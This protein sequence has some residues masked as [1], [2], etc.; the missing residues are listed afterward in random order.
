MRDNAL[1]ALGAIVLLTAYA[2]ASLYPF[3]PLRWGFPRPVSNGAELLQEGGI[4]FAAPGIARSSGPPDWVAAALRSHRLELSLRLR[5]FAPDQDGPARILTLSSG[6]LRRNLTLAQDGD[7]LTIRLRTPAT[8]LNGTYFDGTPVARIADVFATPAWVDLRIGIE[9]G[10]LRVEVDGEARAR[11]TLPAAP[12]QGWNPGYPLALGN[13]LTHNRAWLGEIRRA[14]VSGAHGAV[15]YARA[16]ALELPAR[17]W[18][19]IG[20][21]TLVPFGE[22]S[23]RDAALNLTGYVPLGLFLGA[24][25]RWRGWHAAWPIG[26]A[27]LVSASFET[28]QFVVADRHPS[29]TDL[30][31]NTLGGAL[32]VLLTLWPGRARWQALFGKRFRPGAG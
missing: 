15:D 4:R 6:P 3:H 32:G 7:D 14:V 23:L 2:I 10:E 5:S 18:S 11:T 17:F 25:G 26:L 29:T 12:L 21:H 1:F 20:P 16:G 31:L 27:F 13:E 22:R 30:L 19:A 8:G 24:W 28:L 9:P